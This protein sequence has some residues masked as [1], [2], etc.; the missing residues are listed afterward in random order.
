MDGSPAK[1]EVMKP[2]D[3]KKI[4]VG[5]GGL[6][7]A[8]ANR[9]SEVT[10]FAR[11]SKLFDR[12]VLA[13]SFED[14]LEIACNDNG[15]GTYSLMYIPKS[16]GELQ[17]NILGEGQP[18]VGSPFS[19]EVKPEP[20]PQLCV[21]SGRAVE[22]PD[23]C[24]LV[25]ETVELTVDSTKAG[26][27]HL[28][29]T[30]TQPNRAALRVFTTEEK[31]A[32]KHLHYLKF[33]PKIVGPYTLSLSWSNDPIPGSPFQ[34]QV[35]D[36][37]KCHMEDPIPCAILVGES[38]SFVVKTRGGGSG[39]LKVVPS[40]SNV[41]AVLEE[42]AFE[43]TVV[44]LSGL[45]LGESSLKVTFGGHDIPRTPFT[46][47]VCDPSQCKIVNEDPQL[48]SQIVKV[49]SPFG[50]EVVTEN[51][52]KA[53]LQVKP[54]D[55]THQCRIDV[56]QRPDRGHSWEVSGTAE[57]IGEQ[58]LVV[59]WGGVQIPDGL[60]RFTACDPG[61][62]I[63]AGLPDAKNFIP[64]T[65]E[66]FNFTIDYSKAGVCQQLSAQAKLSE[67]VTE[68]LGTETE[69][70]VATISC[71]PKQP[72]K[73]ELILRF[74]GFDILTT[75]WVCDVPD[76]T[77]FRVTPPK[78]YAKQKETV[79][80]PITGVTEET[81]NFSISAVHSEEEAT[82]STDSGKEDSTVIVRFN[83]RHIGEYR[84]EVKHAE[85]H[86]DGSPF[87]VLVANPDGCEIE[88]DIPEFVHVRST[89]TVTVVTSSAGPGELTCPAETIVGEI[90]VIPEIVAGRKADP[91]YPSP[92]KWSESIASMQ[93]GRITC[94]RALPSMSALW[95]S[96]R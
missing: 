32:E 31:T 8:I 40:G 81:Q 56:R 86:I 3:F 68:D 83:A 29:V 50:F 39:K 27:G 10:V 53:E 69:G 67:G 34:I 11:E 51:A 85:Q 91:L 59:L 37:S 77:R 20:N 1:F 71:T 33:D 55:P 87:T 14:G 9:S 25:S 41:K 6:K 90:D 17:L 4:T 52:G 22:D 58:E 63:I 72:G 24:L 2:V 80:F 89:G 12:G 74:N 42:A 79:V 30:G 13:V 5:G 88:G 15:N 48:A 61:K 35:V 28:T 60:V 54:R 16:A 46:V 7:Q 75:P 64:I 26:T 47:G 62:C 93:S 45:E 38:Q 96:R 82:V 65:G 94:C 84:V 92:Q 76:P 73:L 36:P 23:T 44:Q 66:P 49:G 57:D 18:I 19:I 95:M 21:V 70:A 78:G 43:S